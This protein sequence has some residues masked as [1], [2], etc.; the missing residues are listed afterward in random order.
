MFM[1]SSGPTLRSL[2]LL[3]LLGLLCLAPR[4]SAQI[5]NVVFFDDFSTPGI[6]PSKYAVDAPFFEG[7]KGTIAPKIADGVLEFTGEVTERWWAGA[8]LRLANTYTASAETN[9]VVSVDRVA[10]WGVGTASRSALW[11]MDET[12]TKYVLFADVRAEGGWRYNRKIGESGDVPTGSGT[13]IAAFNSFDANLGTD[14][15]DGGLHRMK[16]VID[17]RNVSLYLDGKFGATVKFPFEKVILHLG[18]YARNGPPDPVPDTAHTVFDNLRVEEVGR[19]TF[20]ITSLTIGTGQTASDLLVRIPPGANANAPVVVRVASNRP[21]VA[22]AAG[23]TAGSLA[24]TFEQGGPN[25]K[26][27][28]LQALTIGSAQLTLTND[29]GLLAGNTMAVSVTAGPGV[30]MEDTFSGATLD[31]GKWRVNTQSFEA[32]SGP[33]EVTQSGGVL[34]ISG[35]VETQYWPGASIQTVGDFS[36]SKDLLLSFEVDRV[37]IDPT[38]L[39]MEDSSGARTGIFITSYDVSNNRA[40]PSVL[41]AQNVGETG[42]QVNVNPG[43]PTGSGT[44][45]PAFSSLAA[46]RGKHRMKLLADGSMVEVFLDGVS[47]GKFDMPLG[48]F[49]KFELG[50]YARDW[51]DAVVGVFDNV[52]IENVLPCI[53]VSPSDFTTIQG[54]SGSSVAVTI[55]KLLSSTGDAKVTVT[56]RNPNVAVPQGAVSGSLVLTFATGRTNTQRFNVVAVGAGTTT[57]DVTND[58]G[59]CVASGI[60]ITIT[61]PPVTLLSDDFAGTSID[62]SKWAQDTT[63]LVTGGLATADSFLRLTNGTVFMNVVCEAADWPGFTLWTSDS[64]DASA[65]SPVV[66]EIDRTRMEYVLVGGTSAK[67]RTGIW[68]RNAQGNYVFFSDFGSWDGT[69][70]GWQYHRS[71]GQAGDTPATGGGVYITPFNAAR[72]TDQRDHRMKAVA[73]GNSVK[74]FLDGELGVEVP[75][76]FSEDLVFGFGSYV[77]FGNNANNIVRGF[78]DNALVQGFRAQPP[79]S[80]L[81]VTRQG[82]NVV[83]TWTGTGTLQSTDSLSPMAWTDVTPAPAGNTITVSPAAKTQTYYRL[84]Q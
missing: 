31:A 76:P 11:I 38:S 5:T 53:N 44:A 13:D 82:G 50:A 39:W 57:F 26:T 74:L 84:R 28:N 58:K 16:A 55:P 49:L 67:Q 51:D 6:S 72:F 24:L 25:T 30:L 43:N 19:A 32:G 60:S 59:A 40:A 79:G 78:W 1:K 15:D 70:G 10:E 34:T 7:G 35:S 27:F 46:D 61:P 65:I 23:A 18:S 20:G 17:G 52:K 62:S 66:F 9:L 14:F 33:F 2:S 37:S 77:N 69:P 3:C 8:T 21:A 48:A 4:T 71:I 83:I 80:S 64:Y 29:T 36:A 75:F 56:S 22:A 54:D 45:L 42:W 81:G 63:P 73:N 47:G 41:F 68:V 12:Q